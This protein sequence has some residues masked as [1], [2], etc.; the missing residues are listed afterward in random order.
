MIDI[1]THILPFVDDGSEDE[2]TSLEMLK[3]LK[4]EG[5][6]DVILTPHYRGKYR[7]SPAKL[8]GAFEKFNQLKTENNIDVNLYLGEE[9][10]DL[11]DFASTKLGKRTITLNDSKFVLIEF[12]Y[13]SACDI[14][15]HAYNV[16]TFGLVPIIAHVERYEYITFD[17]VQELKS[18]KALIQVN[19]SSVV[20]KAPKF[21]RKITKKLLK[22]RLVD[23][24][25]SDIHD[26]REPCLQKAYKLV[27]RRYGF[28]YAN[29]I[30][31]ENAKEIIK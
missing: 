17:L 16:Y 5:V 23:F 9:I 18:V 15:E 25:A 14:V 10:F 29:K 1:H 4:K 11:I 19:A 7:P 30:F 24:V 21:S 28:N 26:G 8:K 27:K 20:G 2:K 3:L 22:H 6:T 31:N 12:P 13:F